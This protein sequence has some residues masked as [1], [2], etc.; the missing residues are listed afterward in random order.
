MHARKQGAVRVTLFTVLRLF[1]LAMFL[2]QTAN[3]MN[4]DSCDLWNLKLNAREQY[5]QGISLWNDKK[6]LKKYIPELNNILSA[7]KT[8][9]GD[10]NIFDKY[11][12]KNPHAICN[13]TLKYFYLQTSRGSDKEIAELLWTPLG[14]INLP[15]LDMANIRPHLIEIFK[16]IDITRGVNTWSLSD[17]FADNARIFCLFIS[18]RKTAKYKGERIIYWIAPREHEVLESSQAS[19]ALFDFLCMA[20]FRDQIFQNIIDEIWH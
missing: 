20:D 6:R 9:H 4:E 3:A 11:S 15:Y 17:Y 14:R 5:K 1:C 8:A 18:P 7:I 19:D 2:L 16:L 13:R 10:D 12:Y